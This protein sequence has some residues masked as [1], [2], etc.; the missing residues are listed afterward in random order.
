MKSGTILVAAAVDTEIDFL[1]EIIKDVKSCKMCGY[2]AFEGKLE[3]YKV[4]ILKTGVGI[5]NATISTM[6]AINKYNPEIVINEGTAGSHS[7]DIKRGDLIIGNKVVYIGGYKTPIKGLNEESNSLEWTIT[8]FQQKDDSNT[9]EYKAD[10]KLIDL[11]KEIN[12]FKYGK[13]RIGTIGSGDVFNKEIDRINYI[14]NKL[15]TSCEEMESAAVYKVAQTL[16]VPVIG[17]RIISNNELLN[18]KYD[19]KYGKYSQEFTYTFLKK[20]IMRK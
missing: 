20:Y 17:F 15:D 6:L 18:E 10:E 7:L 3:N 9:T 14:H 11:A 2:T 8:D 13:I 4:I 16:N 5:I 19:V 1:K 12:D